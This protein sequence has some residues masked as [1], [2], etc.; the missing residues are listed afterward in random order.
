MSRLRGWSWLAGLVMF[1][2]GLPG[3]FA[4]GAVWWGWLGSASAATP[5]V[6]TLVGVAVGELSAPVRSTSTANEAARL[7]TR[8]ATRQD[9]YEQTAPSEP[10]RRGTSSIVTSAFVGLRDRLAD[11]AYERARR[12]PDAPK[13]PETLRLEEAVLAKIAPDQLGLV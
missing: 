4:D 6:V 2:V 12:P 9:L 8:P 10:S 3:T 7:A 13:A 5:Y 1:V 11:E